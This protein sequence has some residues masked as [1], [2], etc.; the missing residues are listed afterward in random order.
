M[1]IVLSLDEYNFNI[2]E[3]T[4]QG[5]GGGSGGGKG[6]GELGVVEVRQD[7]PDTAFWEATAVTKPTARPPSWF[8]CRIT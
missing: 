1:P 4:V 3:E 7:F 2:Q 6:E 5:A 8:P